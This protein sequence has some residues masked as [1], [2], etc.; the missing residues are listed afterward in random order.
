MTVNE[1]KMIVNEDLLIIKLFFCQTVYI[2][3]TEL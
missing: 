3:L 2:D 1:E